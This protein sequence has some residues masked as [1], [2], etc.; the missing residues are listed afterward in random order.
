MILIHTQT[1]IAVLQHLSLG[2]ILQS[3]NFLLS[4]EESKDLFDHFETKEYIII[5]EYIINQTRPIS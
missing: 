5:P 1:N 3:V 2:N 4:K